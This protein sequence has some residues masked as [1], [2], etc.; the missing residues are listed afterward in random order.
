[1][2]TLTEKERNEEKLIRKICTVKFED[3]KFLGKS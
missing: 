1:M 3:P 2:R